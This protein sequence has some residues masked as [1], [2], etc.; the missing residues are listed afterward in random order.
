MPEKIPK[1]KKEVAPASASTPST[2]KKICYTPPTDHFT[3]E[4]LT[5]FIGN[6]IFYA[7]FYFFILRPM[8]QRFEAQNQALDAQMLQIKAMLGTK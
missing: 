7:G 2:S 1:Q 6:T 3:R 5:N 8:I 4:I